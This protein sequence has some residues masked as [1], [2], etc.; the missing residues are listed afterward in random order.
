MTKKP[1][2][3]VRRKILD[4]A[5]ILF[6]QQGFDATGINQIAKTAGITKSLI[7][8]YFK[9]KD[10]ILSELFQEFVH[11]SIEKKK[12]ITDMTWK[13]DSKYDVNTILKDYTLPFLMSQKNIIKIA[14]TESVKE[15]PTTPHINI[16]R[17]FDQNFKAGNE[18]AGQYGIEADKEI[19]YLSGFFLFWMPLFSFVIFS[20]EWC[21]YYHCELESVIDLFVTAYGKM[22]E[23]LFG[24][25]GEQAHFNQIFKFNNQNS[26]GGGK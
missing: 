14:F 23:T 4:T 6:A 12:Q 5:E 21:D 20:D 24:L 19:A 13:K 26:L 2:E 15:A 22:Y 10:E 17:Y 7:Y 3:D 8:Y 18:I 1:K 11:Q 9:S 25:R 16:F